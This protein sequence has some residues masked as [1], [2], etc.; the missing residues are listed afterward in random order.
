MSS[1][2]GS[3][4]NWFTGDF[5]GR[6]LGLILQEVGNRRPEALTS[7]IGIVC[8]IPRQK[9]KN[10][11]FQAEYSFPGMRGKRRADIA[12]FFDDEDEPS[13]LIEIKYYDKPMPETESKPAQLED[14]RAWRNSDRENRHVI[15]LSRELYGA[16]D[17]DVR[18]WN[19]FAQHLRPYAEKSDLIDML[20]KYL[21]E[22][23]NV[24]QNINGGALTKYIKRY[25]CYSKAGANNVEGPVE[26]SNLLKNVQ[27]LSG[28]FHGH[29]KSAWK[30]AG[31]KIEGESYARRSKV[32][33]IDFNVWNRLKS[34]K[35]G[36]SVVDGQGGL[37]NDL[38]DGGTISVFA[39]HSLGHG[40]NW[41]RVDYGLWFNVSPDDSEGDP[42]EACL[43]AD[44]RGGTLVRA[45]TQIS[46]SKKIN[47]NWV[48][49]E[50]ER[51]SDAVEGKLN[52]LILIAVAKLLDSK[53]LLQ[54]QQKKALTL[55][56]RSLSSG[57]LPSL[58][59]T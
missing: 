7:F 53:I 4:Q 27:L 16:D 29:F 18:R 43:F 26:F 13:V 39:Q 33:S 48:T 8:G 58:T 11:R 34:V 55:L 51:R 40:Q 46:T 5:H 24:M 17:I 57:L 19:S 45:G 10:P 32:A 56:N 9:L 54:P 59:V 37:R 47:F 31:V 28:N 14:Y 6:H 38:K 41:L 15:L 42:P 3:I 21:Q 25:L 35:K 2:F 12:I 30:E 20:V 52:Q 50:S 23:G 36:I 22:E 44:I 49:S 1:F